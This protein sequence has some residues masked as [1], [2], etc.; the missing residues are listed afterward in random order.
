MGCL[1]HGCKTEPG[2][3][4]RQIPGEEA[5]ERL[6]QGKAFISIELEL[7]CLRCG[8]RLQLCQLAVGENV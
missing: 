3:I 4:D 8:K 5:T 1:F 2:G 7:V 6:H